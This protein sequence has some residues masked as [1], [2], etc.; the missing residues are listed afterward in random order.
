MRESMIE[1][2]VVSASIVGDRNAAAILFDQ[3]EQVEANL[4][5]FSVD[6]AIK[7]ACVYDLGVDYAP[8][9]SRDCRPRRHY[10]SS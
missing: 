2:L 5:L 3:H 6:P 1:R 9:S 7:Q 8:D 4:R 10:P